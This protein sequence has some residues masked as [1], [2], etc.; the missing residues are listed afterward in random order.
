MFIAVSFALAFALLNRGRGSH[1]GNEIDS[2]VASRLIT[3]FGMAI[4]TMIAA[5][6]DEYRGNMI[7]VWAFVGVS[8]WEWFGWDNYW[9]AAIGNPTNIMK[10][11]FPPV[12]WL[13]ARLPFFKSLYLAQGTPFKLRLWGAVAMGLRQSLATPCI[14]GLAF[15][16][17]H[18]DHA[19][20]AAGTLLFGL[21]YFIAGYLYPKAP[22][23]VAD[24]VVGGALGFIFYFTIH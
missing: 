15:L 22:V 19:W 23:M 11:C 14:I 3:S 17:G 2:T 21:P 18:P 6:A 10:P 24:Y 16:T 9:S 20:Y 8:V 13:M 7:L 1:F 12:D 5:Q 4:L